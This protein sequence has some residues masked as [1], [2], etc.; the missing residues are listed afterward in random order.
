MHVSDRGP[1]ALYNHWIG[2]LIT[3]D[4]R[5]TLGAMVGCAVTLATALRLDLGVGNGY[6]EW[7]FT[8]WDALY[9]EL[10]E[11]TTTLRPVR[12]THRPGN[13]RFLGTATP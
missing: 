12:G 9:D 11:A 4:K 5:N 3:A 1:L 13:S 2:D 7:R 8:P 10:R 6:I